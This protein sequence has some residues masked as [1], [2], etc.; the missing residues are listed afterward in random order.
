MQGEEFKFN[1]PKFQSK[2]KAMPVILLLDVSGSMSHDGKIEHLNEAVLDMMTAFNKEM[3]SSERIYK[4]A[5]ITFGTGATVA[6][7]FDEPVKIL[8]R[9]RDLKAGGQTYLGA[10]LLKAKKMIENREIVPSYWY[11]PA[12]LLLSD[13]KPYGE[14]KGYWEECMDEFC[15][16]GRSGSKTQ[17]FAIA[18]GAD[19]DTNILGQF[20]G[21]SSNVM[22][23]EDATELLKNFREV[24]NTVSKRYNAPDPNK[25]VNY[26]KFNFDNAN[27]PKPTAY[28][29]RRKKRTDQSDDVD[30]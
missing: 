1:A 11:N 16:Q 13:G 21:N 29:S 10:A 15:N 23:A 18:L 24:T 2:V 27:T 19:A 17:R 30:Y 25:F 14:D 7:E 4:V 5:V 6:E 8:E 9:Y 20:T 3:T 12:V 26:G 22:H 28:S